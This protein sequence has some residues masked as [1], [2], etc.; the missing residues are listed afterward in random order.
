MKNQIQNFI[1]SFEPRQAAIQANR[2]LSPEGKQKALERLDTEKRE[3]LRAFVPELRAAAVAAAVEADKFQGCAWAAGQLETQ[4]W[5]YTRLMYESQ[6]IKAAMTRAGGDVYAAAELWQSIEGTHD[7]YK[8]KAAIDTIPLEV[9][10]TEQ[11]AARIAELHDALNAGSHYLQSAEVADYNRQAL[12][13]AANL[14][15]IRAAA[16]LLD[17]TLHANPITGMHPIMERNIMHGIKTEGDKVKIDFRP[18]IKRN[19]EPETPEELARRL[20]D[21]WR[22]KNAEQIQFAAEQGMTLTPADVD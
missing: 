2:E 7:K 10:A 18:T 22:A 13:A 4:T 9:K 14:A 16:R 1:D 6:S 17:K 8:I 12:D 21:E 11:Q 3:G 19:G 20:D 15:E 5:D